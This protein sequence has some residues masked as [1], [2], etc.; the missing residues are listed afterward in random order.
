MAVFVVE[1]FIPSLTAEGVQ[2]QD[3]QERELAA[4][5]D[6]LRHVRT[7]YLQED[8]LCFSFFE[9][10]SAQALREANERARMPFERISEAIDAGSGL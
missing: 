1:R 6:G 3:A 7:T 4:S 5:T 2:A 9:A 8:E 10:P